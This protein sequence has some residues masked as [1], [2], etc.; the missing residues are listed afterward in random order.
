MLRLNYYQIT[1]ALGATIGERIVGSVG[2][3]TYKGIAGKMARSLRSRDP[4][5]TELRD[6]GDGASQ[7]TKRLRAALEASRNGFSP[8]RVIADPSLNAS[9]IEECRTFGFENDAFT[10]NKSLLQLRKAGKLSGLNSKRTTVPDQWRFAYAS[11]IAGR[12]VCLHYGVS[13]DTMLCHPGLV[14]HF[15]TLATRLAPQAN[16]FQCRWCALNIR[17]R[18]LSELETARSLVKHLRWSKLGQL[19]ALRRIPEKPGICEL[20]EGKQL[21][22]VCGSGNLLETAEHHRAL[23]H[24]PVLDRNLWNPRPESLL[25]R[26]SITNGN[27]VRMPS[28]VSALVGQY[29]PLFNIPRAGRTH[30]A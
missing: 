5:L 11:E 26:Y 19:Q 18:G 4:Y 12:A 8:D 3:Q 10:L 30:A 20:L 29:S 21:L 23:I 24:V 27:G 22:L 13:I 17:K 6:H 25:W 9:F 1:A 15:D 7:F 28:L 14:Q 16:A 2:P